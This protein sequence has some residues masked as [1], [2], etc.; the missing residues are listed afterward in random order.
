M[1]DGTLAPR[2]WIATSVAEIRWYIEQGRFL[3]HWYMRDHV[4][5]AARKHDGASVD[6]YEDTPD[7]WSAFECQ[8][9]GETFDANDGYGSTNWNGLGMDCCGCGNECGA[10]TCSSP[11]SPSRHPLQRAHAPPG[12][13]GQAIAERGGASR[14]ARA[15]VGRFTTAMSRMAPSRS[16]SRTTRTRKSYATWGP[17]APTASQR[18]WRRRVPSRRGLAV[19]PTRAVRSHTGWCHA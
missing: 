11:F 3:Q 18:C 8:L 10:A 5:M 14:G 15:T 6:T 12:L 16:V 2:A 1:F 13:M 7:V 9:C 19:P 4:E 17:P